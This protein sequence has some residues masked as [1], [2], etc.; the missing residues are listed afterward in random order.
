[1]H[2][3]TGLFLRLRRAVRRRAHDRDMA[4][5]MHDH[6]DRETARRIAAGEDPAT[7]RRRAAAAFGSV[8]AATEQVRDHRV[9]AWFEHLVRDIRYAGRSLRRHPGFTTVAILTLAFGIGVNTSMFT[10]LQS[11]L[12]R[13]L[14][15]PEPDRLVQVFR[16][17]PHSQR[18]PHSPANFLDQRRENDVFEFMAATHSRPFN[19]AEPGQPP[20]RVRGLQVT[21]DFFPMLGVPPALGRAFTAD[22]D[23]PGADTVA[24]LDHTFWQRRFAGDPGIVGRTLR[25]DGETVTI[26]GVMPPTFGD[27]A[28]FG[29]V[30]VWRPMAFSEELRRN[31]GG[32]FLQAFARLKPGV[33]L[34]QAQA[35]MDA[36]AARQARTHPDNN[37]GIGLRLSLLRDA[38]DPRGKLALALTMMLAGFVLLIACAN[39]ANLQFARTARRT[40]E[41]AIRSALGAPRVRL[42]RQ[43]LMESLLIAVL[44]GLLGLVLAHWGNAA[45]SHF[46]THD[47]KPALTLK[48]NLLVLGFAFGASMI[49]GLAFGLMPAWLASR[50]NALAA[51]RSG[52]RGIGGDRPRRR[53][54]HALIVAEV[55]LTLVLLS[56]AGL[57]GRGLHRFAAQDPGWTVDNLTIGTLNLPDGKYGQADA[58]RT[59]AEHLAAKL[60]ATPGAEQVALAWS[61]PVREFNTAGGFD[62]ADRTPP[63]PGQEPLW[64]LNAVS[65]GYFA[66]L[67][68]RLL[69]GRPFNAADTAGQ[70]GVVI[71]NETMARTWW[72]DTSPIGLR[73]GGMEII[74]V[75]NDVGFATDP[76]APATRFQAYRPL[77]QEPRNHLAVA[78]RGSVTAETLR[79]AVAELDPDL[80]VINPGSAADE[81]GRAMGNLTAVGWLLGAFATLGLL[82][83]CLG[84]YGVIA[85]FVAHRTAEIGIRV[86]LG[87]QRRDVLGL[88]VGRGMRL[89]LLGIAAGALGALAL[90]RAI[91]GFLP[92]LGVTDPWTIGLLATL[93]LAVATLAS[94]LPARRATNVDPIAALRS[95]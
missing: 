66:T 40:H 33:S 5:E 73:A 58:Q 69:A 1:M 38:M 12:M 14:P 71:I 25:L 63:A 28:A 67:D 65:P 91:G 88:V 36:L 4:A 35:A 16:T 94:W 11:V 41:L 62:I 24:M 59:F 83:A 6:L 54:Q 51:T 60:S 55:A 22:E 75:V 68:M 45:L 31:R 47:G 86:A 43:L 90:A 15:F 46:I 79:R 77:A 53:L 44:G 61:L 57:V 29:H 81:V 48:L 34:V 50:T 10:A 23:R 76:S 18:W 89:T 32:N 2:L 30:D 74:G 92:G 3:L 39:L 27:Q 72:P 84:I 70:P 26:I 80:P 87:A 13:E 64:F 49:S 56:G 93:L 37:T 8:D 95:E 17:S 42:L 9:G 21:S 20:E 52:S 78:I 19:L 82:L 85:G 7:A